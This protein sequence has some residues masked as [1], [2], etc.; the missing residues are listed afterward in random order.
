MPP[1]SER[2][3]FLSYASQDADATRR[4][5]AA[6]RAARVEVWFDQSELRGGEAWDSKIRQ[7]IK[8]CALFVPIISAN[9][10]ARREGYFRREWNFACDRMLDM[11]RG[12]TF[13]LPVVVD[14]TAERAAL[15]PEEFLRVQWMRLSLQPIRGEPAGEACVQ[16]VE[17][18]QRLLAPHSTVGRRPPPQ[19]HVPTRA[20]ELGDLGRPREMRVTKRTWPAVL[21]TST[22]LIAAAAVA[23]AVWLPRSKPS[24]V[25]DLRATPLTANAGWEGQP[26]FSPDGNQVAY[27]WNGEKQDNP[28]IYVKLIGAGAP[29]RLTTD[30]SIDDNPTWSP[31]GRWIAFLR[32][33]AGKS[34]RA[35]I[36]LIPALGGAERPIGEVR[37][38]LSS[39]GWR[40]YV[41]WTPNS[42]WLVVS[43]ESAE[44]E[45]AGLFLL[46]PDTGERRRLTTIG[47]P[48]SPALSPNGRRLAFVRSAGM[49]T[50]D[51]YLLE[52]TAD[53]LP[54]GEPARLT[55]LNEGIC[56][57]VWTADGRDIL[58][59]V[60]GHLAPRSLRRITAVPGSAPRREPIGEDSETLAIARARRRLV[61][62]RETGD[63][64]VWRVALRSRTEL[65]GPPA[66][67]L[68]SIANDFNPEYS[69]DGKR[70]VFN[71]HRSGT[72]EVWVANADGTNALQ[73]SNVAGPMVANPRWSPDGRSIAIHSMR[74]GEKGLDVIGASGGAFTR[75]LVASVTWPSWSRDGKWIYFGSRGQLR[76]IPRD[77]GAATQVTQE[78]GSGTAFESADGKFLYY[79]KPPEVRK[80]PL[81][82]G[83][84]T[85]VLDEPLSYGMNMALVEDGLYLISAGSGEA[86][87]RLL[88]YEFATG[89]VTELLKIPRWGYGLAVSPDG[90]TLLYGQEEESR[91]SLMLVE[92]FQ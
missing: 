27:V 92:N 83:P 69:R 8:E 58:F 6:L 49:S 14:A 65:A 13:L 2:A 87:G 70:I 86:E 74:G 44:G 25:A 9:T 35:T 18:V 60:G 55:A 64:D 50:G 91:S 21:F 36:I 34:G 78:G 40:G 53:F 51:I 81:E 12:T 84:E 11:T 3:V 89:R 16:F 43:S 75:L 72:Q 23:L 77:G 30:P 79:V 42:K 73:L 56:N 54:Q 71:S 82:G 80:M 90:K 20:A 31:D 48:Y 57:P 4:L 63:T 5:C 39:V 7:Q 19:Q 88:F 24:A 52:L 33:L 68:A 15:V 38:R 47:S 37:V 85:V 46:S 10:Q 45:S 28:D 41:A 26:T 17:Q 29:L 22:G 62:A 59:S 67:L 61:Y 32:V 1:A 66:K 76:K